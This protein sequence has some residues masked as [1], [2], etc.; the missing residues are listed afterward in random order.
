MQLVFKSF[1]KSA[2][3]WSAVCK[4]SIFLPYSVSFCNLLVSITFLLQ[5]AD[6]FNQWCITIYII[7]TYSSIYWAEYTSLNTLHLVAMQTFKAGDSTECLQERCLSVYSHRMTKL[8][9]VEGLV[10]PNFKQG[11]WV[12]EWSNLTMSGLSY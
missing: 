5:S 6:F 9:T 4:S 12:T 8:K 3:G 2:L 10:K 11:K 7:S 1:S